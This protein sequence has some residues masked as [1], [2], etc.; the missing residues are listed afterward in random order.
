MLGNAFLNK[1]SKKVDG[2]PS[3]SFRKHRHHQ[4]QGKI[5]RKDLKDKNLTF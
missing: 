1:T 5:D 3:R 4:D 2:L